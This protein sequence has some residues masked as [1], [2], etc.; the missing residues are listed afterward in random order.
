MWLHSWQKV[1][2]QIFTDIICRCEVYIG[3]RIASVLLR[4]IAY[5]YYFPLEAFCFGLFRLY[6]VCCRSHMH[7]AVDQ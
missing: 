5:D 1:K 6:Q 7:S 3:L 4:S 2:V